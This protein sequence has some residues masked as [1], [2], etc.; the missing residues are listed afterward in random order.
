LRESIE[1]YEEIFGPVAEACPRIRGP[2][3]GGSP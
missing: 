2:G 3:C 1:Q